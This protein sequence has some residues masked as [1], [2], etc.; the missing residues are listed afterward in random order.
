MNAKKFVAALLL[1][2]GTSFVGASRVW[3]AV[4]CVTQYGTAAGY[5]QVCVKT[6]EIQINKEVFDSQTKKFVDNLGPSAFK[7]APGDEVTFRLKIKN[8]GDNTL[9]K[10]QVTDTLPS[11]LESVA[12]EFKFE[13][14][15]LK[16]DQVVEKELKARFVSIDKLPQDKS[17]VCDFNKAEVVSGDKKDEDKAEVCVEKKAV[18]ELPKAGSEDTVS[19]IVASLVAG[20]VGLG[21]VRVRSAWKI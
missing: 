14:T 21:L 19:T 18:R 8:I 9:G 6:G 15:D 20:L 5:G 11:I 4:S 10:V 17:V 2:V 12:G 7:F 13:L 16:V 3:A 1:F